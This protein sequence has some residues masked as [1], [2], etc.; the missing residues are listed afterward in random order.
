M[1][2][3][4]FNHDAPLARHTLARAEELN[5]KL[6]AVAAGFD[7]LPSEAVLK[8][9]RVTHATAAGAADSYHLT[10]PYPPTAYTEGMRVTFRVPAGAGNAGASAVNINGLGVKPILRI[11]GTPPTGGDLPAGGVIDLCYDGT[12][13]RLVGAHGGD[14]AV[15]RGYAGEAA[16][17]AA[18]AAGS[19][20]TA[21]T[22][23]GEAAA[24]ANAAT[25]SAATATTKAG[26][27]ATSAANAAGSATT[28]T[29]KAGEAAASANAATTSAATAT[30][31]AGEAA[32]S[33]AN[34]AGSASAAAASAA[35]VN[36][37][38]VTAA[39]AGKVLT[40]T[41]AGAWALQAPGVAV[42]VNGGA[43]TTRPAINLIAGAGVEF[44]L[45][46]NPSASRVDLTLSAARPVTLD[47]ANRGADVRLSADWL[48]ATVA[49][50]H[51]QRGG[52]RATVGRSS[53]KW[54]FEVSGGFREETGVGF[55]SAA[56]NVAAVDI[57]YASGSVFVL[58]IPYA[59]YLLVNGTWIPIGGENV[60]GDN[61][62][63]IACD[64]DAGKWWH[65]VNGVWQSGG[66]PLTG[67]NSFQ[68][69]PSGVIYPLIHIRVK[70][71][72]ETLSMHFHA[73]TWQYAAPAGY[74][75]W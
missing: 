40:A 27:A 1:T 11:D 61:V 9:G 36:L 41:S 53:G 69:L 31:K 65:S 7:R 66:N 25:T 62:I 24:S 21:T 28:A 35:G 10:L 57:R 72:G 42:Q 13:F 14:V 75:Q 58:G 70:G 33:A 18:N 4:Y 46:D 20:T 71:P 49:Q 34:A 43:G 50:E 3:G 55:V 26:E 17:S 12:A 45:T 59:K 54:Y 5:A 16:T 32:T 64:I 73:Q 47:P 63:G 74:N 29:T 68:G 22:K 48:T 37:P 30:T 15:A 56:V 39:D 8:Q 19:A 51:T 67:V 2:N 52:C 44:V 38:S 6:T 23:A 60:H